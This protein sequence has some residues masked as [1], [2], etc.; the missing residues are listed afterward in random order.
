VRT[1]WRREDS[2]GAEDDDPN[3]YADTAVLHGTAPPQRCFNS[4]QH[5]Q[6][7]IT[8]PHGEPLS[9]PLALRPVFFRERRRRSRRCMPGREWC[10]PSPFRCK[11]KARTHAHPHEPIWGGTKPPE[12]GT[13]PQAPH[14]EHARHGQSMAMARMF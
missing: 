10:K 7:I 3:G 1:R 14:A 6:P 11:H 4:P 13:R 2:T 5:R 12:P 8:D 9:S